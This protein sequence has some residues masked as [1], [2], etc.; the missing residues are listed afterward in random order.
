ML[1]EG[2]SSGSGSGLFFLLSSFFGGGD[3]SCSQDAAVGLGGEG[4]A[5]SS[6]DKLRGI[7]RASLYFYGG[8]F[9]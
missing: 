9:L 5:D 4:F 2:S 6:A 7:D 8:R 3:C 1:F